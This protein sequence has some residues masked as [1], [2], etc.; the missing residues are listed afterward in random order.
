VRRDHEKRSR[1]TLP[2]PGTQGS[3]EEPFGRAR[4]FERLFGNRRCILMGLRCRGSFECPCVRGMPDCTSYLYVEVLTVMCIVVGI[5]RKPAKTAFIFPRGLENTLEYPV[6]LQYTA[7]VP[8]TLWRARSAKLPQGS[9]RCCRRLER[10]S[11]QFVRSPLGFGFP[12]PPPGAE[13]LP[14]LLRTLPWGILHVACPRRGGCPPL[15]GGGR[16]AGSTMEPS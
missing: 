2:L 6:P 1:G 10:R 11:T 4:G 3:G 14:G 9:H 5:I 15:D 7:I 13:T 12:F 8:F 16:A